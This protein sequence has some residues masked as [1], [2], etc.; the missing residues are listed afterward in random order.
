MK[1]TLLLALLSLTL[2]AAC[3]TMSQ[4]PAAAADVNGVITSINGGMVTVKAASGDVQVTVGRGTQVFWPNGS[5][6]DRANLTVG[7]SVDVWL[8]AGTQTAA[9]V[10][11]KS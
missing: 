9:R 4:A 11:I 6:G 5:E 1:R 3:A 2:I 10:N 7:H 8:S